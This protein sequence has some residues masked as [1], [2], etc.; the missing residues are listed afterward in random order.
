[1]ITS[2]SPKRSIARALRCSSHS[3]AIRSSSSR[4]S[5]LS[6]ASNP[7]ESA[8]ITSTR[9]ADR[10]SISSLISVSVLIPLK[11]PAGW[12]VFL[13]ISELVQPVLVDPEV[14]GELVEDR[15]PDLLLE[16]PRVGERLDEGP[17]EDRD[18]VREELVGLP[19]A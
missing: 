17:P 9:R 7:S 14:V 5:A 13:R 11:T 18:L 3:S 15:D 10:W 2:R 12:A 6:V 8:R 19:E 4:C 16:L 1:M